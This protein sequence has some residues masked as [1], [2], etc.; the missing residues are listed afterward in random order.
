MTLWKVATGAIR[1]SY[2]YRL[3]GP[4]FTIYGH[5]RHGTR[6]KARSGSSHAD[7]S[8]T[9]S[10]EIFSVYVSNYFCD[11]PEKG[12]VRFTTCCELSFC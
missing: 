11:T 7:S 12:G 9:L 2:P 4:T 8:V 3:A 1:V 5:N 6:Q 10:C